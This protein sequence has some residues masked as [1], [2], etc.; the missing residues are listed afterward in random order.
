MSMPRRLG[1]GD[2]D[3]HDHQQDGAAF[4]QRAQRQ[5]QQVDQQQEAHCRQVEAVEEDL[6]RLRHVLPW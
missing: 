1:G 4:E 3:G 2:Q 5:Q 6:H